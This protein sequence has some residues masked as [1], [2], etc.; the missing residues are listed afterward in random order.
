MVT[1]A[2]FFSREW[3]K[4][5]KEA[6]VAWCERHMPANEVVWPGL[7]DFILAIV[8]YTAITLLIPHIRT[9]LGETPESFVQ[10]TSPLAER[11][12][13]L[14]FACTVPALWRTLSNYRRSL[15]VFARTVERYKFLAPSSL[16][17]L[18]AAVSIWVAVPGKW[19]SSV[20]VLFPV[21]IAFVTLGGFLFTLNKLDDILSR[22]HSYAVL[23][24]HLERMIKREKERADAGPSPGQLL[25]MANAVSFGNISAVERYSP[26]HETLGKALAHPDINVRIICRDWGAD[27]VI[28]A[29]LTRQQLD[30]VCHHPEGLPEATVDVIRKT[31]LG[32]FY[33]A[34]ENSAGWNVESL[35]G[36][37]YE[38]ISLIDAVRSSHPNGKTSVTKA[39]WTIPQGHVPFHMVLTTDRALLFHVLDFPIRGNPRP[40]R[41]QV[42]GSEVGDAATVQ[43]LLRSFGHHAE[44]LGSPK[45]AKSPTGCAAYDLKSD[46]VLYG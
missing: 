24:D 19:T 21:G 28:P 16:L 3:W 20:G 8:G 10:R 44:Q 27:L 41:I 25:I 34:W 13:K 18:L 14:L 22:I 38:A 4:E 31:S 39:V 17:L 33:W 35:K 7:I 43:Q 15:G 32:A 9:W 12:C 5:R 6:F 23:L 42:I 36:P 45:I 40:P 30:R 37:Y 26:I 11:S 2:R 1:T 46:P 29:E